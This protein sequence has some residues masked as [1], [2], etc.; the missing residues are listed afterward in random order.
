[1]ILAELRLRDYKQF[2]GEHV[3]TPERQGIT[4]VIGPNGAGKTTLFEAIEWCLYG[5][6][7]IPNA[8]VFPRGREGRP[9]VTVKLEDPVTGQRYVIQRKLKSKTMQAEVWREENPEEILATG[10]APVRAFVAGQL[11]GLGHDAFVSTFFTRQKELS[12]FGSMRPTERRVMVGRLI[13]VEA[14][15]MA[16]EQI[17]NERSQAATRAEGLKAQVEHE[18]SDRDLDAEIAAAQTATD[19]ATVLVAQRDA[20]HA[21][22]RQALDRANEDAERIRLREQQDRSLADRLATLGAAQGRL[23]AE[24]ISVDRELARLA[25]ES[26]RRASLEPLAAGQPVH[27]A[28]VERWSTES[29]RHE[30]L[31]DLRKQLSGAEQERN[32]AATAAAELVT[33]SATPIVPAWRWNGGDPAEQIAA[34]LGVATTVDAGGARSEAQLLQHYLSRRGEVERANEELT[35][36]RKR[37]EQLRRDEAAL[38]KAGDP[39]LAIARLDKQITAQQ[40]DAARISSEADQARAHAAQLTPLLRSLREKEYGDHCPTC[41]RDIAEG[42]ADQVIKTLAEHHASWTQLAIQ[43]DIESN[44]VRLTLEELNAELKNERKRESELTDVRSRLAQGEQLTTEKAADL[45]RLEKETADLLRDSGRTTAPTSSDLQQVQ[46]RADALT[47]INEAAQGLTQRRAH[48]ATLADSERQ[49]SA[50]IAELGAPVYDREQHAAAEQALAEANRAIA[51]LQQIDR[52][53]ARI[54]AFTEQRTRCTAEL[55]GIATDAAAI[56]EERVKLGYQEQESVKARETLAHATGEERQQKDQPARTSRRA[57]T[58]DPAKGA[59]PG[60]L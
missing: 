58:P 38:L 37:L 10:S 27:L 46:H 30:R 33:N 18:L 59:A 7:S 49:L 31:G 52:D 21:K 53:L 56:S 47:A 36:Y 60:A 16:Q 39:A 13:G 42:E 55:D 9:E 3:I 23:E 45:T 19:E 6:R 28:A 41:G 1:M 34:L 35:R 40:V 51:A 22:A 5:P 2:S 48:L 12:F 26:T 32:R 29:R 25:E 24:L 44:Q 15:R 20:D 8:D 50:Q 14:V 57:K 4:A 11:I 43:R 54:P 17:G